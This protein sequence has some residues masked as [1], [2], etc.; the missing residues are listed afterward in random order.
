[1]ETVHAAEEWQ[2][3][4]VHYVRTQAMCLGFGVSLEMEFGEDTP[5]DDYILV[6]HRGLPAATCR[7]RL[8]AQ[9]HGHIERVAT[10]ENFRGQGFGRAAIAAAEDFLKEKGASQIYINSREAVLGFYEKLGYTAIPDSRS[11]AGEFVC[12]MTRKDV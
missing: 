5:E 8:D 7:M 4:G 6:M 11:G 3:A 1:M 12:I 9:G 2:R 10:L